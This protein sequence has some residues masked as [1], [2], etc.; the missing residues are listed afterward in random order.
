MKKIMFFILLTANLAVAAQTKISIEDFQPA[1]GTWKCQLTYLDYTS[2]K[3]ESIPANTKVEIKGKSR[4]KMAIYY[5]NEPSRNGKDLYRIRE[6]GT[7]IND[8]RVIERTLLAD[9]KLKIV[10]ESKGPDGNDHK[11]ATFH[12]ELLIGKNTFTMTKRVRFDGEEN[13]FQ[14][15][16]YA[17][18]R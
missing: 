2:G 11:P 1:A 7:M 17:F 15:N 6:N 10:L 14:R 16:Q 4:V 13:F 18:T 12:H 5:T 3:Q 8:Q 9:G